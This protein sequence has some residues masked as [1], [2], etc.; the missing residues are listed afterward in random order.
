MRSLTVLAT[1]AMLLSIPACQLQQ[2]QD[3]KTGETAS[4]ETKVLPPLHLGAV[5]QVYPQQGFALLRMIGPIPPGGSVL[6]THPMDGSNSRMGNLIVSS[7]YNSRGNII[8]ADI[9]SGEV[10]K[11][12]R[13][14][15]Y[16]NILSQVEE[17]ESDT[18]TTPT[19]RPI[20]D[21]VSDEAVEA[22]LRAEAGDVPEQEPTPEPEQP[23]VEP[24]N[25]APSATP[26]VEIPSYLDEIPDEI[27]GWH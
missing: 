17:E 9:R 16:R 22:A 8:A 26:S 6:I 10:V 5:H 4:A 15:L 25:P 27:H 1:A 21:T 3:T 19:A 18:E 23:I 24:V 13:V 2:Q 12:D 7:E 20:L 14:F 11:G